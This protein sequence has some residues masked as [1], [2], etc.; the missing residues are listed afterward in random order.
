METRQQHWNAIYKSRDEREVSWFEAFPAIPWKW[1]TLSDW[2]PTRAS[3]MWAV[4]NHVWSMRY[5]PDSLAAELGD[6]FKLL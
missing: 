2:S 6:E 3:S 5:S 4:G 1:S